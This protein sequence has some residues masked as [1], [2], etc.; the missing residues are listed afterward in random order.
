MSLREKIVKKLLSRITLITAITWLL[1]VYCLTTLS[2]FANKVHVQEETMTSG[3]AP[4]FI[5]YD[6]VFTASTDVGATLKKIGLPAYQ[7]DVDG[8]AVIDFTVIESK[9]ADTRECLVYAFMTSEGELMEGTPGSAIGLTVAKALTRA[10]W[11]SK[12]IYIVWV[13]KTVGRFAHG[14]K[15]WLDDFLRS[16]SPSLLKE[17]PL[18]RGAF[19][20][21]LTGFGGSLIVDIEGVNG[22]LPNQDVSNLFFDVAEEVNF[23]VTTRSVYE[24]ML[25]SA[26]NGGVHTLHTA[27]L[28]YGI[29]SMTLKRA[30]TTLAR[31][32]AS[33]P[34]VMHTAQVVG[35]H[36]RAFTGLYHQMHHSTNFFIYV[37]PWMEVGLGTYILAA[38]GFISP[39]FR[40]VVGPEANNEPVWL[41]ASLIGIVFSAIFL[42]GGGLLMNLAILADPHS[43][44][45]PTAQ[46][47]PERILRATPIPLALSL[48]HVR[49]CMWLRRKAGGDFGLSLR[50]VTQ[51]WYSAVFTFIILYHWCSAI[52]ASSVVIPVLAL[53]SPLRRNKPIQS[54]IGLCV[55]LGAWLTV[56]RYLMSYSVV[57][58]PIKDYMI[59]VLS[60]LVALLKDG[61]LGKNSPFL[62]FL[63]FVRRVLLGSVRISTSV[64]RMVTEFYCVSGLALPILCMVIYPAL[65]LAVEVMISGA[66]ASDACEDKNRSVKDAS[67]RK[68]IRALAIGVISVGIYLCMYE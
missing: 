26:L 62:E 15:E 10:N 3:G 35:K 14:L 40:G 39:I 64:S 38:V 6:D 45:S 68:M 67:R 19:A 56:G 18:I 43:C 59:K 16:A 65:L 8:R 12:D 4:P 29:P 58:Q 36:I 60:D 61:S 57:P 24:S 33:S 48:L 52:I 30:N 46:L 47:T 44:V 54:I 55:V 50:G 66:G 9:R 11:L 31:H 49:L 37:G 20:V 1:S 32:S 5:Q 28:D 23:S 25:Y 63:T 34:S 22:M 2:Q 7:F 42:I 17:K 41:S 53:V 51:K 21:D 27:F 13:P